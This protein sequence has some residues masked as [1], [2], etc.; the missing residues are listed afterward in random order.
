[1]TEN[2]RTEEEFD[3][4]LD[5]ASYFCTELQSGLSP[6]AALI[7]SVQYFGDQT[8]EIIAKSTKFIIEGTA[9]FVSAWSSIIQEY[10]G[11]RYHRILELFGRFLERG[12]QIG[13]ERMLRI[14]AQIRKNLVLAK[15]RRNLIRAQAVKIL[16]LSI[17]SSAVLGMVAGLTPIIT[18]ALTGI[19]IG[20]GWQ[21]T[22]YL[23]FVQV[24]ITLFLTVM[25]SSYKLNQAVGRSTKN[26][27][28]CAVAY[29]ICFLL[30][31]N[32]LSTIF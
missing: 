21:P 18:T 20:N 1:M 19:Y 32:M 23:M 14:L 8:P 26:I 17:V 15:N 9:S 22:N 16:A 13:A 3:I 5:F 11:T 7:R 6:E 4:F 10:R 27:I 24:F 31:T 12:T 28:I 30:V 29:T 2:E 25:I